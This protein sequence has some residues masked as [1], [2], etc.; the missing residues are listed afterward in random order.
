MGML[1]VG[2][3]TREMRRLDLQLGCFDGNI[4]YTSRA[5]VLRTVACCTVRGRVVV[6]IGFGRGQGQ[7][8]MNPFPSAEILGNS[9]CAGNTYLQ[10]CTVAVKRFH[11]PPLH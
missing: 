7:A 4:Y 11:L 3:Y 8:R 10:D 9:V 1:A 6:I 5:D 2:A